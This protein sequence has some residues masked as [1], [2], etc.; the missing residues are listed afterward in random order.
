MPAGEEI[1]MLMAREVIGWND[2]YFKLTAT[3]PR[4]SSDIALAWKI[5][6]KCQTYKVGTPS[7]KGDVFAIVQIRGV[8]ALATADTAPLA[9][10]RAA[11][12][13]AR[14]RG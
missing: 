2:S 4:H 10:C 12:L 5:L 6:A 7:N 9:I 14:E 11:L 1:D 8:S 3:A 13:A